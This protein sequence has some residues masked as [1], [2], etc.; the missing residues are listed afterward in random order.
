MIERINVP[1]R[2]PLSDEE[3][4]Q[5]GE[6]H[7]T[8]ANISRAIEAQDPESIVTDDEEPGTVAQ[9]PNNTLDQSAE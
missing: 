2:T 1:R 4:I 3:V 5:H 8:A 9:N 6:D 7:L